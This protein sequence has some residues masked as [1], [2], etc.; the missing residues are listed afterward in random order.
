[1]A[2]KRSKAI[3]ERNNKLIKQYRI[4]LKSMSHTKAIKKLI[5]DEEFDL[6]ERQIRRIL[7]NE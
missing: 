1:M 3:I 4:L 6:G 5:R 2:G 7:N